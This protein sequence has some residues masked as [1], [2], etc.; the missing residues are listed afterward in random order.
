MSKNLN[1]QNP[2]QPNHFEGLSDVLK[3]HFIDLVINSKITSKPIFN[4][5]GT[6]KRIKIIN[7]LVDKEVNAL[8]ERFPDFSSE[9]LVQL[10]KTS[11]YLE[12]LKNLLEEAS[13]KN[14][15]AYKKTLKV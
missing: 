10:M 5:F 7:S 14:S 3:Q 1:L 8:Q 13:Y 9:E 6:Q 4:R 11:N 2:T 12:R 15:W